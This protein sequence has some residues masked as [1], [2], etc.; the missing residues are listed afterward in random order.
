[1]S[2]VRVHQAKGEDLDLAPRRL[3]GGATIAADV[4]IAGP[5]TSL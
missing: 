4:Q 5:R 3:E 1:V 2:A